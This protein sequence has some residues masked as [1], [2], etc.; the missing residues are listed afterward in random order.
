MLRQMA[1]IVAPH[2][3]GI[4]FLTDGAG[5]HLAVEGRCLGLLDPIPGMTDAGEG[6]QR[7]RCGQRDDK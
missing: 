5:K 7:R 4:G 3:A 6:N 2:E 1:G